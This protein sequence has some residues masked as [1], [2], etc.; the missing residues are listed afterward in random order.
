MITKEEAIKAYNDLIQLRRSEVLV[1]DKTN[2]GKIEIH[3][4]LPKSCGGLDVDDNKIAL[5]AKEH[6][7]AHVYLWIIHHED[8]FYYQTTYALVGMCKGTLN[9]SRQELR[10]FILKSEEYQRAKEKFVIY[11]SQT[12]SN[13]NNKKKNGAFGKHWYSND[14]LQKSALFFD[15]NVPCNWKIGYKFQN[16]TREKS[17]QKIIA[18]A[19]NIELQ[20]R[21]NACREVFFSLY[22]DYYL[23]HGFD[24][25]VKK[26]DLQIERTAL[27]HMFKKYV[28]YYKAYNRWK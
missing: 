25:T 8:E 21:I 7:M 18:R 12:I 17:I 22:Y 28:P 1:K 11:T 10:D 19:N 6:F 4:I 5:Y 9:G 13:K 2:K 15:T 14:L 3:H 26:F 16:K 20:K 27:L 24:L 23:Q